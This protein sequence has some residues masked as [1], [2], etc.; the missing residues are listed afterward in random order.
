MR[1]SLIA[2]VTL[3]AAAALLWQFTGDEHSDDVVAAGGEIAVG[4]G[5][6]IGPSLD[7]A[8]H[9][10]PRIVERQPADL[11]SPGEEPVTA[12]SVQASLE[13]QRPRGEV[14]HAPS[15][16]A[17]SE[18]PSPDPEFSPDPV[19]DLIQTMIMDGAPAEMIE[20]FER[21]F[22]LAAMTPE[23]RREAEALEPQ[24]EPPTPEQVEDLIWHAYSNGDIP[25]DVVDGLVEAHWRQVEAE[26][27]LARERDEA[28]SPN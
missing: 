24:Y 13:D 20:D 7:V 23:E 5:R 15:P 27:R 21:S 6:E 19:N 3:L 12:P 18:L 25:A 1:I 22:M 2:S 17:D 16:V 4:T 14:K 28:R 9:R 11:G 26:E 10:E 8:A